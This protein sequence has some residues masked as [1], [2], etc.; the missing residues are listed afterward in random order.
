MVN[1]RAAIEQIEGR[2]IIDSR[3][4][5]TVEA[6]VT[7]A[8]GTVCTGAAPGNPSGEAEDKSR[9]VILAVPAAVSNINNTVNIALKG[10]DASNTAL[11]DS[12]LIRADGTENRSRLGANAMLAVS[13]AAAGAAARHYD[14]PLYRFIGGTS[15]SVMP[16]PV[17]SVLNGGTYD[18]LDIRDFMIIPKR[19][20]SFREGLTRCIEVHRRLSAILRQKGL[21]NSAGNGFS[22]EREAIELILE[23]IER[24]GFR[25]REDFVLGLDAAAGRWT[26]GGGGYILPGKKLSRTSD[27]LIYEWK[28]L[29][30]RYPIAYLED[31]LG[32]D[33]FEGRKKLTAELG[34]KLQIVGNRVLGNGLSR[35]KRS[36]EYG[37]ENTAAIKLEQHSTLTE[38]LAAVR[39]AKRNGYKT[40]ISRSEAE[41]EDVFIADLSVAIN[42]GQIRI[43]APRGGERTA[44]YNRLIRI[45]EEL[46]KVVIT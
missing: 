38:A 26:S 13:L 35:L 11:V 36:I 3:G 16:L 18:S 2:E 15:G 31:P 27:E 17:M 1:S 14:L 12:A 24:A 25:P 28:S 34:G 20:G 10:L 6:E 39:L 32:D 29:C 19:A 46:G 40:V 41:T 43:G 42:S 30:E 21:L 4:N 45:E 23:A 5:P 33:D 8:D 7:L 22:G 37:C 44:K 9:R